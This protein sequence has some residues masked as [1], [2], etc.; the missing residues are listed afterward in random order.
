MKIRSTFTDGQGRETTRVY[1]V[2]G[3]PD[4]MP[5]QSTVEHV[6]RDRTVSE[7][8]VVRTDNDGNFWSSVRYER[9]DR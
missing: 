1:T 5:H 7:F 6:F 2:P 9:I 4:D 8:T 3:S